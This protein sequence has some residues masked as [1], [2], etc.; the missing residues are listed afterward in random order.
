MRRLDESIWQDDVAKFPVI[1][2][3]AWFDAARLEARRF[4]D[5]VR[6]ECGFVHRA[7]PERRRRP[8]ARPE[9]VADDLVRV[10]LAHEFGPFAR[11]CGA[12]REARHGEIETSPEEMH[13]TRLAEKA[14]ARKIGRAHV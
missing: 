6:V 11:R 9:A 12:P 3:T 2:R 1:E 14:T 13:R 5:G 8:A 4:R 7:R 10:R